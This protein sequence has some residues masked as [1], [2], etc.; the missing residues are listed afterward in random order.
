MEMIFFSILNIVR[1]LEEGL[2]F[3][4]LNRMLYF[5]NGYSFILGN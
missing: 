1:M 4:N 2:L 3:W 5:W